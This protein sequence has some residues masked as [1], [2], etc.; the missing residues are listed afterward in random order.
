MHT[1]EDKLRA[2]KLA[3]E[4]LDYGLTLIKP[5]ASYLAVYKAIIQ[6][7]HDLGAKPAFPPQMACDDVAAHYIPGLNEDIIF[8]KQL[9]SLDVGVCVNG[10]IGDCACSIDLSGKHEK[11]LV[12]VDD[13]LKQAISHIKVGVTLGEI[14]QIIDQTAA[15]YGFM[16]I[17]NLSGHGLGH[18]QVHTPPN[19]PNYNNHSQITITND[20][21][22]AIEPFI[23]TGC[24]TIYDAGN[25][26]IFSFVQKKPVRSLF[27][28]ELLKHIK[29]FET[30]PFS[31]QD[32]AHTMPAAKLQLALRELL[33]AGILQG[34]APLIEQEH[35]IVAQ[36]EHT[37]YVDESG[38]V[39]VT[40]DS[41]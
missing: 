39:H 19:I 9:V 24:G 11:L 20:M 4:T 8:D 41:K 6:K 22:F 33:Q 30:L 26:Q 25:P 38:V 5:G 10:A 3:R 34:H 35:G 14:G 13:V 18:N 2:G 31:I 32:I 1:K 7:I 36:K 23:T 12:A 37:I 28:R 17:R 40:T 21:H 15:K 29:Q 16:A 27:A